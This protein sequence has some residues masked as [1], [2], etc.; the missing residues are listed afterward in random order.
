MNLDALTAT[1]AVIGA[2]ITAIYGVYK[3]AIGQVKPTDQSI[4]PTLPSMVGQYTSGLK[5]IE[6]A[7]QSAVRV[8]HDRKRTVENI[9]S[10]Q[11]RSVGEL[12]SINRMLGRIEN[13]Q[14]HL[15]RALE[16][17]KNHDETAVQI[18]GQ[19]REFVKVRGMH[20]SG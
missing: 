2:I 9:S 10:H 18:L 4:A 13:N 11:Q 12:E 19:I 5:D 6:E 15:H 8:L 14:D 3:A 16:T 20:R 17:I 7:L 1:I